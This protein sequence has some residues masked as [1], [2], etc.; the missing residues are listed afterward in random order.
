M[1]CIGQH[2]VNLSLMCKTHCPICFRNLYIAFSQSKHLEQRSLSLSLL[3]LIFAQ[4]FLS[5]PQ[6]TIIHSALRYCFSLHTHESV[7]LKYECAMI[8]ILTPLL[9]SLSLFI[10]IMLKWLSCDFRAS[11]SCK[12]PLHNVYVYH[13]NYFKLQE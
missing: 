11:V 4:P 5:V 2:C 3:L 10:I 1:C 7:I 9:C 6:S 13:I 8:E 12:C